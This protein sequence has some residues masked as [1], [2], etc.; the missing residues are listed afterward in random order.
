MSLVCPPAAAGKR[1]VEQLAARA[2]IDFDA[3]YS[4][5]ERAATPQG[6]VV[7]L[8]CD[9]NGVV[10]RH[11]A[12]RPSTAQAA[13]ASSTKLKPGCLRARKRNRKRLAEV[14]AV[15]EIAPA[16]RTAADVLPASEPQRVEAVPGPMPATSG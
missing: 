16:P 1:Q 15:Y 9:G 3:F 2:A 12:L 7:V 8:S 11:D 6:S 4:Q 13:K 10:M 14:G 5:R